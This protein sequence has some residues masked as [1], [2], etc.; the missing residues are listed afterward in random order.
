MTDD[1]ADPFLDSAPPRS[2]DSARRRVIAWSIAFVAIAAV[3]ASL[4]ALA[5]AA[6]TPQ[7]TVVLAVLPHPDDEFQM[8]SLLEDTPDQYK[9]FVSLT[10]GEQTYHCDAEGLAA[11]LQTER[12]ELAPQPPPEGR[13]SRECEQARMTSLLG[14]LGEMSEAD[15][16]IPGDFDDWR[17]VGPLADDGTPICRTDEVEDCSSERRSIRIAEDRQGRGAVV[18]FDLGDG[19]LTESEATWAI[20]Q[21][22][23]SHGEWDLDV[24]DR[25]AAIIGAFANDSASC[26]EYSH[27]DHMAVR[28]ALWNTSFGGGPQIGATCFTDPAQ[29]YS[30][31]V[32]RAAAD[33]AFARGQDGERLGAHGRHYGWLHSVAYPLTGVFQ[34][35]LFM[36]FQSFWIRHN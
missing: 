16:S 28:A 35:E 31:F 3:T 26:F 27:P 13:W 22:V 30:V 2:R 32:S 11:G 10:Y 7:R 23:A 15:D 5:F 8:W 24:E 34:S 25:I 12:G 17:S 19:D 20:R 1:I 6:T 29:R 33:Q 36:R 4:L 9:I 18:F 21:L 14:F